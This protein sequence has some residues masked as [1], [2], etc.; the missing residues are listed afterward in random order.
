MTA[1]FD[2]AMDVLRGWARA[3]A[4][5]T[6]VFRST[7]GDV[8]FNCGGYIV[9]L[10]DDGVTISHASGAY[11]F[12]VSLVTAA[13]I[14]YQ[15]PSGAPLHVAEWANANIVSSMS[16]RF[17]TGYECILYEVRREVAAAQQQ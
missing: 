16:V 6:G 15:D 9:D 8:L 7:H 3:K 10:A 17:P 5:L 2:E 12:T 4:P 11:K 13:D 14:D 1:T